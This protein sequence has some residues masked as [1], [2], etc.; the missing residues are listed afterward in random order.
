MQAAATGRRPALVGARR[1]RR[2]AEAAQDLLAGR[3]TTH[4]ELVAFKDW[5]QVREHSTQDDASG[6]LQVLVKLIDEHSPEQIIRMVGGLVD[7]RSADVVIS[8]PTKLRAASGTA[9]GSPG[10]S[11]NPDSTRS[12]ARQS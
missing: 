8:R 2:R 3:P 1:H 5:D 11:A 4:P 6:N 7:E 10:T 12:P 9:F